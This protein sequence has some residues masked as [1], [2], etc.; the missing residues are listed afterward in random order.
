MSMPWLFS[1]LG[2]SAS[3]RCGGF[4]SGVWAL[5]VRN[6]MPERRA[7]LLTAICE[8]LRVVCPARDGNIGHAVVEQIFCA[9][10][11]IHVNKQTICGLALTVV[12]GHRIAVIHGCRCGSKFML[13]S[14]SS[15]NR[16]VPSCAMPSTVP[17]SRF[18][19]FI[20]LFGAVNWMR[21]HTE[22]ALSCS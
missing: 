12:A 21:S 5:L 18:T 3:S 7:E 6:I 8:D 1:C 4:R 20:S 10:L 17:N 14:L 9:K 2:V 13:R 11:C 16:I 19:I 22:N 15:F